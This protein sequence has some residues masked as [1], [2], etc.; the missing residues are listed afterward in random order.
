VADRIDY[1][2]DTPLQCTIDGAA[3]AQSI[4]FGMFGVRAEFSGD[5]RI[6][7]QPPAFAPKIELKGLKLRGHVLDIAVQ[8][9]EYEVRADANRIS[10]AVGQSIVVRGSQLLR[11]DN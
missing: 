10:T 11:G 8:G 2:K 3:V 1:R 6:H 5:I 4:I 9:G 7:P